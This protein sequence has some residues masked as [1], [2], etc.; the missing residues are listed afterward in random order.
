MILAAV[1]VC[2]D[3]DRNGWRYEFAVVQVRCDE[4]YFNLEVEGEYWGWEIDDIDFFVP[5]HPSKEK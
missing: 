2:H 5:I 1:A 4:H 3:G